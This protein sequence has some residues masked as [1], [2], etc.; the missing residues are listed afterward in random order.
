MRTVIL[1]PRRPDGGPRDLLW[2]W[3]RTRW[4]REHPDLEVFEGAHPGKGPFNRALALNRA[5]AAAGDWDVAVVADADSFVGADQVD[6]AIGLAATSGQMV[7]AFDRWCA[8]DEAM[9]TQILGGYDG[10]WWPGVTVAMTDTCSSMFAV[11]RPLWDECAGFDER[12]Q[13]WG[14]EDFSFA[15]AARTFGDG[16][17]RIEGACWHLWHPTGRRDPARVAANVA[18][19][20][21]YH[22]AA[23]DPDAMR[24][25]IAEATS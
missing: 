20:D 19:A 4:G 8:L 12:H 9:T 5:A 21:R 14:A 25:L 2:D 1:V 16:W 11:P 13:G 7:M 3:C 24:A 15:H 6:T 17:Q 10:N 18:L 22:A 23:G